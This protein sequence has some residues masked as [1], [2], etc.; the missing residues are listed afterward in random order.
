MT[1]DFSVATPVATAS[2][3][4]TVFAVSHVLKPARK[5]FVFVDEGKVEVDPVAPALESLTVSPGIAANVSETE[6]SSAPTA[7]LKPPVVLGKKSFTTSRSQIT[8]KGHITSDGSIAF[9]EGKTGKGNYSPLQPAKTS[10]LREGKS[11][12]SKK[13]KLRMGKNLVLV[14]AVD[15]FGARSKPARIE[16]TRMKAR[17]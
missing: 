9:I 13:V 15:V 1:S 4:G 12:W 8:V 5:T 14:R 7:E 3:R 17:R 11:L 2:V 6:I 16:I 10:T